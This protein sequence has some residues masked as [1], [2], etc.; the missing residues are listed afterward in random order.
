MRIRIDTTL[1][2]KHTEDK[3]K[4]SGCDVFNADEKKGSIG[5]VE[6]SLNCL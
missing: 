5:P 3:N 6:I 4:R 2:L 1:F